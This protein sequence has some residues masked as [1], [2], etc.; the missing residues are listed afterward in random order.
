MWV[1][2]LACVWRA[3]QRSWGPLGTPSLLIIPGG[4]T[5]EIPA[6]LKYLKF[7][8]SSL[9]SVKKKIFLNIYF[10]QKSMIRPGMWLFRFSE[11]FAG[12]TISEVHV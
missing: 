3:F 10:I 6:I 11:F 5:L 8:N 12:K 1:I 2:V 4:E 7:E 9:R